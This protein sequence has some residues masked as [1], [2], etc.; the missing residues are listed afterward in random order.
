MAPRGPK[1]VPKR[2]KMAPRCGPR[3]PQE[4]PKMAPTHHHSPHATDP[5]HVTGPGGMRVALTIKDTHLG[6]RRRR[7]K[8]KNAPTESGPLPDYT[9]GS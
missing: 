6:E 8:K 9:Q 2:P 7:R 5:W 1:M 3:A 4:G